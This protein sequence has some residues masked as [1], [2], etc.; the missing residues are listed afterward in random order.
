M[1][2]RQSA[3]ERVSSAKRARA[4][5]E[6]RS[7]CLPYAGAVHIRRHRVSYRG[8]SRWLRFKLAPVPADQ[9]LIRGNQRH[10]RVDPNPSVTRENLYVEMQMAAGAV[11]AVEVVGDDANFL[12]LLDVAAVQDL[13][14]IHGRRVH[15]HV[16]EANVFGLG[17]DLQR[18]P[19][20]LWRADQDAV[21]DRDDALPFRVTVI[22]Y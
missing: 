16:T 13:V 9:P 5:L 7:C 11:G 2:R 6:L 14:G 19:L 15:V 21:A 22:G 4:I 12:A 8:R 20:L 17:V 3:N 10:I 18:H 1:E